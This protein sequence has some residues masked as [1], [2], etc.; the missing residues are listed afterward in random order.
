MPWLQN[1][2]SCMQYTLLFTW[3]PAAVGIPMQIPVRRQ[4]Y[5]QGQNPLYLF[6]KFLETILG[7]I[8]MKAG[9]F[10]FE[11]VF[12]IALLF[13]SK[14]KD[15]LRRNL[16]NVLG[17]PA[18]KKELKQNYKNYARYYYE[19]C[20]DKEK[21]MPHVIITD[22]YKRSRAR[23]RELHEKYGG[24]ILISMHMGNWDFAG[25]YLS[26]IFPNVANV[27]VERLSPEL[28]KWFEKTRRK[29]GMKIVTADNGREIIKV[30]RNHEVLV[31]MGDRDLQKTGH[32]IDF[33][34]KKAYIPSGPAKL[35]LAFQ[36]PLM[37][38][39]LTRDRK[40]P[41]KFIPDFNYDAL[42]LEKLERTPENEL[43]LTRDMVAIME[44]YVKKYPDQWCML[45]DVWVNN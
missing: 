8:P 27:V 30:L 3:Q 21:L 41:Y 34:G 17:R 15:A 36:V 2:Q 22:D 32:Q 23:A 13:P 12:S 38:A 42:N 45:Q 29:F 10:L 39:C 26:E 31:L 5:K 44:K 24:F 37:L 6:L 35:S 28:F 4:I 7:N 14:R 25:C 19:L 1:F 43:Q 18:A 16:S 9:Y 20:V 33:C 40:N 11:T